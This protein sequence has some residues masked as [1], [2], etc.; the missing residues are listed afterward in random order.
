MDKKRRKPFL[1]WY[2]RVTTTLPRKDG[3]LMY[4]YYNR[5]Q[6]ILPM[7]L[8]ILIPKHHLCRIVDLAVEK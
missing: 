4:I 2:N 7:D 1:F 5:D 6:L 3:F 8:E